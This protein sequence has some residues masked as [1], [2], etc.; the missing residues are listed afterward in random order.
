M[1][2]IYVDTDI[3]DEL[4]NEFG[5]RTEWPP[6]LRIAQQLLSVV[7]RHLDED[8]AGVL[9]NAASMAC[10]A[11]RRHNQAERPYAEILQEAVDLSVIEDR[12]ALA[13]V[14][15]VM[16][17][18]HDTLGSDDWARFV[19]AAGAALDERRLINA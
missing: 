4:R 1:T 15:A 16:L 5:K 2:D 14:W 18:A 6:R 10:A 7:V 17:A 19:H 12:A 8:D 13:D 9:L 3:H 11:H